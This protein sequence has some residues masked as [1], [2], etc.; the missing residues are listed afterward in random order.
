MISPTA[1][2]ILLAAAAGAA[3]GQTASTDRPVT[4]VATPRGSGVELKVVG[5]SSTALEASYTLDVSGGSGTA[6]N[7]SVQSGRAILKPGVPVTLATLNLGGPSTNW[8]ATL[9][10]RPNGREAYDIESHAGD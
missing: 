4:L 3:A 2:A 6:K 9:H 7:R 1:G 10:V 8:S 5:S